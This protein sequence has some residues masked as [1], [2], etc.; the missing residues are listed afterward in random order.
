MILYKLILS[1]LIFSFSTSLCAEPLFDVHLHYNASDARQ[2]SLQ[3][4]IDK[5]ER[6]GIKRAVVTGTPNLHTQELYQY[7]PEHIIPLLGVYRSHEDKLSWSNDV[8]LP[9]RIESELK[10]GVWRGIGEL[11][12]FAKDRHNPVFRRIVKIAAHHKLY[13][14]IHG[15]PAVIDSVYDINPS[16]PVIWAHAG[17]YPYPDLLADYL[18]RYPSL[19]IDLSVR[20]TNIAHNGQINDDWY[21]LFIKFPDRFMI[22]VDTYSLSRW[23]KFDAAVATIRNWLSQLPDDVAKQLAT[24]NATT[25]FGPTTRSRKNRK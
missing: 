8:S 11:H 19:Y 15:D 20:D 7:A 18:H 24:D 10:N 6:N 4:I 17:T 1:C 14:H 25:F 2:F 16:Q 23:K 5:L 22:G 13:L 21:E 12:I 3:Q 9:S